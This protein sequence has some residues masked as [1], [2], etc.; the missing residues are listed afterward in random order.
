M[1][2]TEMKRIALFVLI[3][4]SISTVTPLANA[5][6]EGC[7]SNWKVDSS[8]S[9]GWK[10]LMK[11][12]EVRGS[13]MAIEV[14]DFD[15]TYSD[16]S[17][18]LGPVSKPTINVLG[19]P[20]L[21][22]YGNT[23]V[24]I[25]ISVQVKDCPGKTEFILQGGTLKEYFGF[26]TNPVFVQ[27]IAKDFAANQTDSFIDFVKAQEFPSCIERLT[28]LIISGASGAI[29]GASGGKLAYTQ[30][31]YGLDL[32]G[33]T[34][35]NLYTG[36]HP[37]A[38]NPI[39]MNLTPGCAW[40]DDSDKTPRRLGISV[41]PNKTCTFAFAFSSNPLFNRLN[42][43]L[44]LGIN[45]TEFKNP[46]Y[47]LESFTVSGPVTKK[48]TITC[49]KGKLTKKITAVNPKCPAGYKKK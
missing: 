1:G 23:K 27:T 16:F 37:R 7:P 14:N 11:A 32:Y 3:F 26:K 47:I 4:T 34:F 49:I 33:R 31:D 12:K 46:I 30:I 15:M 5:V 28:K 29:S 45:P 6:T 38:A 36:G 40:I 20:D 8:I 21:F 9:G 41:P 44:G 43:N 39:L 18:E 22:L 42:A 24:A 13:N 10:E 25:K 48:S 19:V 17:G 2:D 35:C